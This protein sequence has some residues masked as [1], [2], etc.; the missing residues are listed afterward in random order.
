MHEV[1][2]VADDDERELV[3]ELGFFEEVLDFLR[4]V[5]V[6]LAADALNFADLAGASGGLDVLEVDLTVGAQV[7][8]RAEVVVQACARRGSGLG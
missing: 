4:V 5:E 2:A 3:R 7:D 6:A 8:D 1:E